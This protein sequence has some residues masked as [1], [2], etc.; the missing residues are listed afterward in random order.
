MP[1]KSFDLLYNAFCIETRVR[2]IMNCI[3]YYNDGN[4]Y[5]KMTAI[6]CNIGLIK[7]TRFDKN[8]EKKQQ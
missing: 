1:E 5:N 2:M 7:K 6:T 3:Q 4:N 8:E